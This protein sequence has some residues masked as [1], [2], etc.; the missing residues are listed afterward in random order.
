MLKIKTK[1]RFLASMLGATAVALPVIGGVAG[2]VGGN[3]TF[4]AASNFDQI[5]DENLKECI[6]TVWSYEKGTV[7]PTSVSNEQ[8]ASLHN[9]GRWNGKTN[10]YPCGGKSIHSLEGVNLLTGLTELTV[11]RNSIESMDLSNNKALTQLNAKNMTDDAVGAEATTTMK[12]VLK[13]VTLP[14]GS[15]LSGVTLRWNA[16]T[17][18][19]VSGDTGLN[20]LDVRGNNISTVKGLENNSNIVGVAVMNNKITSLD[21]SKNTKLEALKAQNNPLDKLDITNNK[22]MYNLQLDADDL[23]YTGVAPVYNLSTE[24]FT[25]DYSDFDFINDTIMV[26][27]VEKQGNKEYVSVSGSKNY[28][29]F[30]FD[31]DSMTLV[32]N[33]HGISQYARVSQD[34]NPSP[35][36]SAINDQRSDFYDNHYLLELYGGVKHGDDAHASGAMLVPYPNYEG[37]PDEVQTLVCSMM[38]SDSCSVVIPTIEREGYT[39]LGWADEPTA[40]TPKYNSGDTMNITG[41]T[42]IFAVWAKYVLDFDANGGNGAPDR[43]G[44]TPESGEACQVTVPDTKPTRDGYTFLGWGT[45]KDDTEAKYKP[46]DKIKLTGNTV[47]YAVWAANKNVPGTPDTGANTKENIVANTVIMLSMLP[48]AGLGMM[49]GMKVLRNKKSHRKFDN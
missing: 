41:Y 29:I 36:A 24:K 31:E 49:L 8:L 33:K 7:F 5:P 12:G 43:I 32:A 48:I 4:A 25:Y 16:L 21:I 1:K 42:E 2:L 20:Y 44:C 6:R 40:T 9:F 14:S 15:A 39:L 28:E 45:K 27:G 11:D 37:A 13:S 30:N 26:S 38:N 19:D 35:D 34:T 22:I 47:L 10:E 23:V 3:N 17:S 46:G 18:I